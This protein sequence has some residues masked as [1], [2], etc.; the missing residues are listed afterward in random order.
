MKIKVNGKEYEAYDL[1][2]R[3]ENFPQDLQK[4]LREFPLVERLIFE[5]DNKDK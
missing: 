1:V 5:Y 3:R 2:M 4:I